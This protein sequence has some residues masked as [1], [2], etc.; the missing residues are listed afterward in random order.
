MV[1]PREVAL[2]SVAYERGMGIILAVFSLPSAHGIGSLGREAYRFIDFLKDSGMKYWQILP[3][4]QTG[5]GDSPYSSFSSFAGNPYYI[6]LDLVRDQGLLTDEDL[7]SEDWGSDPTRVDYGCLYQNRIRLLH[8]AFLRSAGAFD[9]RLADFIE[10]NGWWLKDYALFMSIKDRLEGKAWMQWP[11]SLKMRDREILLRFEEDHRNRIDFYYFIQ[12]L[13][14]QQWKQLKEYARRQGIIIIGDLPIY[15]AMDSADVWANSNLF[16]LDEG[17]R[18]KAVAGVPPDAYSE[19][20][21][22]WGNPLYDWDRMEADG[23]RYWINRVKWLNGLYDIIRLDHFIGFVHYWSI[24]A[25]ELTA[26]NGQW[27]PGPGL[28]LFRVLEAELG[29]LPF[30]LEDLGLL[31]DEVIELREQTGFPGM[32][33]IQFAF[34]GEDSAYLPHN[35]DKRSSIYSSTHDS[36][37]LVGWWKDLDAYSRRYVSNY[38]GLRE[39]DDPIWGILRGIS[40][41]SAQLFLVQMQDL[42]GLDD[43]ARINLPGTT[44]NNWQWR[45]LEGYDNEH[46]VGRLRELAGLY[47]RT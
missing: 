47:G 21:Q 24:P 23:Y 22:N 41:S 44:G 17:L 8:K 35:Q 39:E 26:K 40:A 20:G 12:F 25:G 38:F 11:D 15:S 27:N 6:D 36:S 32:S 34:G 37:T 31:S 42:L 29:P 30:L 4:G 3:L 46:L 19:L 28:K 2:K 13:F 16:L 18:A 14:Y 1:K 43:R 45:L 5:Y 33:V 7:S 10:E 9:D